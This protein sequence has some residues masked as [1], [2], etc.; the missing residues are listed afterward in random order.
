MNKMWR[1][2]IKDGLFP[3]VFFFLLLVSLY[4]LFTLKLQIKKF[5]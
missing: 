1:E 5:F 3:Q 4:V 2:K